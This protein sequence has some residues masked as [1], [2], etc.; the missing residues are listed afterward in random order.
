MLDPRLQCVDR[1]F[2]QTVGSHPSV[3]T[4]VV[5]FDDLPN[6]VR[7]A[8]QDS[9]RGYV[10]SNGIDANGRMIGFVQAGEPA[11]PVE[12]PHELEMLTTGSGDGRLP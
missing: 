6:K 2:S 9:V 12:R 10:L 5:F 4:G 11:V 8:D 1:L 3:V 7:S